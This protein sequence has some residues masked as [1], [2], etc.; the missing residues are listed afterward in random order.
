[1]PIPETAKYFWL[2]KILSAKLNIYSIKWLISHIHTKWSFWFFFLTKRN[3]AFLISPYQA[4]DYF[5]QLF[6]KIEI[7]LGIS[8]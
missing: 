7:T 2:R 8:M 5:L 3:L 4:G 6:W 1:M